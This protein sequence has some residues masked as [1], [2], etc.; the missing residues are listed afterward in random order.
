[1]IPN[2]YGRKAFRA[3]VGGGAGGAALHLSG[4][5]RLLPAQL[6]VGSVSFMLILIATAAAIW[7]AEE[8]LFPSEQSE[9]SDEQPT[10]LPLFLQ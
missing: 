5:V 9:D 1:V 8:K 3:I 10:D 6:F 7:I 4:N 2:E